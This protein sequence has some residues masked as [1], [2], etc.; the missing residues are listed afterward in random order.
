MPKYTQNTDRADEKK[1][2]PIGPV[3]EPKDGKPMRRR[4]R[5]NPVVIN[6]NDAS[7]SLP[8]EDICRKHNELI[9]K[10]EAVPQINDPQDERELGQQTIDKIKIILAKECERGYV[11][12]QDPYK[13]TI[14]HKLGIDI[15]DNHDNDRNREIAI[16][17]LLKN[18]PDLLHTKDWN[19]KTPFSQAIENR[20]QGFLETVLINIP[21]DQQTKVLTSNDG[22]GLTCLNLAFKRHTGDNEFLDMLL[23]YTAPIV[24]VTPDQKGN[25][26]LH[27]LVQNQDFDARSLMGYLTKLLDQG[28]G[29]IEMANT[30]DN[31]TPYQARQNF[32]KKNDGLRVVKGPVTKGQNAESQV[33]YK[34]KKD[35]TQPD[36]HGKVLDEVSESLK[37]CCMMKGGR[38]ERFLYKPGEGIPY[39]FSTIISAGILISKKHLERSVYLDLTSYSKQTIA[40]EDLEYIES[41]NF[42]TILQFVRIP[43]ICIDLT[44]EDDKPTF[45]S[46]HKGHREQRRDVEHVFSWLREKGVKT[47][48]EVDVMDLGCVKPNGGTFDCH[49]DEVIEKALDGFGVVTWDWKRY[50]ICSGTIAT[51]APEVEELYLYS[52]GNPA[53][54]FSWSCDD[55]LG[56]L[57]KVDS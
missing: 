57:K 25:T 12:K 41:P 51:A 53:V 52:R 55:G 56:T 17:Y 23:E 49:S 7:T 27:Y 4:Q 10:I 19:E 26:P 6:K 42:E 37:K 2:G 1:L 13:S 38:V 22:G 3:D 46:R 48:L 34:F 21:P 9:L 28:P 30:P 36:N 16:I 44:S 14:L 11:Q 47:I 33:S 35:C 20:D 32:L 40:D 18:C 54:L 5:R 43:Q 8:D 24:F 31:D 15:N 29:A 39:Y 45:N 50:D